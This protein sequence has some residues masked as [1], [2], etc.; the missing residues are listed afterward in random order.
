MA[1]DAHVSKQALLPGGTGQDSLLLDHGYEVFVHSGGRVDVGLHGA[2]VSWHIGDLTNDVFLNEMLAASAPDKIYN[3]AAVARP[4]LSWDIPNETALLNGLVP[5]RICE[6]VRREMAATRLFQALSFE[7]YRDGPTP[8]QDERTKANPNSPYRISKTY[9]QNHRGLVSSTGCACPLALCSTMRA[10]AGRSI[11]IS[12]NCPCR[13]F[14]WLER[15]AR[16]GRT[17]KADSIGWQA[18][19][20]G[21]LNLRPQFERARPQ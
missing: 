8:L 10:P 18:P 19:Y 11:C 3:P 14:A 15:N 1:S 2:R 13:G 20:L 7:I 4:A 21:D 5:Q 6:F 9:R 17:R 16:T 12:E